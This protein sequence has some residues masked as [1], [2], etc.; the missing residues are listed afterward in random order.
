MSAD[1]FRAQNDRE[2]GESRSCQRVEWKSNGLDS[3]V[4]NAQRQRGKEEE[5][6][7]VMF[8]EHSGCRDL[9]LG[10]HKGILGWLLGAEKRV[11]G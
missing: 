2:S 4:E 11:Q 3:N 8:A 9:V 6:E 1:V 5:E 10:E 7:G